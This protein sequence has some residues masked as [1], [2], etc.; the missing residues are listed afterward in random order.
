MTDERQRD[1]GRRAA[2]YLY[3]ATR[4]DCEVLE[5]FVELIKDADLNVFKS[6]L[7]ELHMRGWQEFDAKYPGVRGT[8]Q[9]ARLIRESGRTGSGNSERRASMTTSETTRPSATILKLVK[10][11]GSDT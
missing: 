11:E 7:L 3:R 9:N 5:I 4:G 8:A 6:R 1:L 2:N 10:Q